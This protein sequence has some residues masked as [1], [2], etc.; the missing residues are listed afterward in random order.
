MGKTVPMFVTPLLFGARRIRARPWSFAA[1]A[2]ALGAAGAL[3]GWATVRAAEA[4]ED[5]VRAGVQALPPAK[6]SFRVVYFTLPFEPDTRAP[7]VAAAMGSFA[8]VG[9][10]P[11][12]I[13][14]WHSLEPGNP[15][16]TRLVVT[17]DVA[18]DVGLRAGRPPSRCTTHVCEAVSLAGSQPTGARVRL[19]PRAVAVVVGRGSLRP[20][21]VPDRGELGQSALLVNGISRPLGAV[22]APHGSTVVTTS[23]LDPR[24]IHGYV[25]GDLRNRLRVAIARLEY[26]DTLVRTGAPLATLG[27]LAE[28]GAV[29]RRRL[30][31]VAG[32]CAALLVAFAAF[33]A[34]MRRRDARTADEQLTNLG[35]TRAQ[36]WGARVTEYVTPGLVGAAL[37]LLGTWLAARVVAS[38]RDLP[39]AFVR[40]VLTW[41][42]VLLIVGAGLGGA[43]LL[44]AMLERR[45]APRGV[46]VLEVAAV[47][48]L[49]VLVWQAST[50]GALQPE[51]VARR[52]TGPLIL[53][54]PALAFFTAA[55]VLLRAV[56]PALRFGERLTRRAP[57]ARLAFVSAARNPADSAAATTFLSV[58]LGGS[59]FSLGY[60]A[61]IERQ[62]REAARFAV[63]ARWRVVGQSRIGSDAIRLDGAVRASV[64]QDLAVRVLALPADRV[65]AVLGWRRSFSH[66]TQ[67]EIARRL[68]PAPVK[69]IGPPLARDATEVR[70]FARSRTDFPRTIVLHLLL[71]GQRFAELTVGTVWRRWR[72]LKARVPPRL[73][74]AQLIA[75]AYEPTR[76]P[77]SFKYDPEGIVDLGPIEQRTSRGWS[78]LPSLAAWNA[79]TLPTGTAGIVYAKRFARA[80]VARGTRFEVNGTFSPLIHPAAGLPTPLPGFTT[81]AL[82]A[83]VSPS[84][85]AHAADGLVT[86]VVAGKQLPVRVRGTA[87]LFPTI[88]DHSSS[89]VVMDYDTL[90]AAL[91]TDQPGIATPTEAWIFGPRAPPAA[92][93]SAERLEE[94]LR[95]DPLA[96]GTRAVLTVTAVVAALLAL[97]GLT[98]AARLTTAAER[99][100]L[101]EYEAIGVAPRS[102][103]RAAQL[104]LSV[105]SVLGIA[106]GALGGLAATWLIGALVAVTGGARRPLPPIVTVVAWVT[107][108]VVISSVVVAAIV[109]AALVVRRS[110]RGPVAGRLRA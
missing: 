85:A 106:A 27:D 90:F 9:S 1:V 75:L 17:T 83:L 69:L 55:V 26:G 28:R 52:G 44:A 42:T 101:A 20:G 61:T 95:D 108:A 104:R 35:A 91:N 84:V 94:R 29:A 86:L 87:D 82:P 66:L 50:T 21:L 97:V 63:G 25:L 4:Q 12:R 30:L 81:G 39:S 48:A 73:R 78:A 8:D 89:F 14:I 32:E 77:I 67:E 45:R 93:L 100:M 68:R 16:G 62:A 47:T 2:V 59:L 109:A 41:P 88:V 107:G 5:S 60:L 57:L 96:A 79:T 65:P 7:A 31:I 98:L 70:V 23:F 38:V 102:L 33:V 80:P 3:I 76:V 6:R 22:A 53:L 74:G 19:G 103:R 15:L 10:A 110:L 54:A 37:A 36:V 71:P 40:S 58:V 49:A 46:G 43:L 51:D 99:P 105:L 34:T 92:S 18:R 11:R 24:R 56:P 13:R 64:G 72:L